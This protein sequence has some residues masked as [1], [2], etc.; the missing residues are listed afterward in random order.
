MTRRCDCYFTLKKKLQ[1]FLKMS[2]SAYSVPVEKQ[3]AVIAQVMQMD[4][5]AVAN[6]VMQKLFSALEMK[7]DFALTEDDK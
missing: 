4:I 6:S 7:Y 5:T 2:L 3:E 1:R